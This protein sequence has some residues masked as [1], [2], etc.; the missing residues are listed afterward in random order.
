MFLVYSSGALGFLDNLHEKASKP[1]L[2]VGTVSKLCVLV[3]YWRPGLI[4]F[5]DIIDYVRAIHK[6]RGHQIQKVPCVCSCAS[7][8][9]DHSQ[10][11]AA[12][13]VY[14]QMLKHWLSGGGESLAPSMCLFPEFKSRLL[15]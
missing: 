7:D 13:G 2:A 10:V 1:G 15:M 4:M 14:W 12:S 9:G 6:L 11:L 3:V 8:F 5:F